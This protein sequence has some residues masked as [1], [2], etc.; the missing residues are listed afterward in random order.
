MQQLFVRGLQGT[1][2]LEDVASLA[3]LRDRVAAAEG[4]DAFAL[5]VGGRPVDEDNVSALHLAT[6]DVCVP[7][8]GGKVS[9]AF[10]YTKSMFEPGVFRR[11][12]GRWRAPAR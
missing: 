9:I 3:E 2:V 12:T 4:V 8:K 10:N 7:L 6:V 11:S 5:F 1:Y